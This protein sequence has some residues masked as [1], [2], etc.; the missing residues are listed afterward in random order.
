MIKVERFVCNMIR[1]NTYVLSDESNECVI[2]DCGAYYAE[3]QRA[4]TE[5]ISRERL[6]PMHL[7]ATHGHIDHNF[8]NKL[9]ADNYQLQV[10]VHHSDE[11]LMQHLDEQAISIAGVTL[12]FK[13][14][15]VGKYLTGSDEILFGSHKLELIETPGHT[16]GSVCFYCKSENLLFTGDTLFQGSVGR[17]DMPGGSMFMLIQSLRTLS[18]MPDETVV[19]PGH[20]ERSTIGDELKQNPYFDR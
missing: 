19:L 7:I 14:P 17:T 15:P 2:I 13:E 20:G 5:Y 9:I 8:G 10:E 1:E 12:D 3:E 11:Q 18:Q 4:I 6:Q 16:K